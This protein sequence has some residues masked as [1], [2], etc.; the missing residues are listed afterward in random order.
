ME[1]DMERETEDEISRQE[2]TEEIKKILQTAHIQL[3]RI[4]RASLQMPSIIRN[5]QNNNAPTRQHKQATDMRICINNIAG[6]DKNMRKLERI[7]DVHE[8]GK[9]RRIPGSRNQHCHKK[10]KI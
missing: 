9:N 7:I 1:S 2:Q 6:T 4:E 3:D 5:T 10:Y 8:L